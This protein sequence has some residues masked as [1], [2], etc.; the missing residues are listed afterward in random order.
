M[1]TKMGCNN[2]VEMHIAIPKQ[3]YPVCVFLPEL[4]EHYRA[5]LH[6]SKLSVVMLLENSDKAHEIQT[7][8]HHKYQRA[9]YHF[10][11]GIGT[12]AIH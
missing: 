11:Y 2:A 10:S 1:D 12:P 4:Q 7:A 8:H 3:I 9:N 6:Q 5:Q